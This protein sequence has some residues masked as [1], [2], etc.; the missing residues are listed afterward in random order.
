MFSILPKV[1]VNDLLTKWIPLPCVGK[2]DSALCSKHGRVQF[3]TFL[4]SGLFDHDSNQSCGGEAFYDWIL[5]RK[6]KLHAK[7]LTLDAVL[8]NNGMVRCKVLSMLGKKLTK[9]SIDSPTATTAQLER[10]ILDVVLY[11]TNLTACNIQRYT[12]LSITSML[13][14]NPNMEKVTLHE[15]ISPKESE[16]LH[17]IGLLCPQIQAIDIRANLEDHSFQSFLSAIPF[18][19][20]CLC[21][22]NCSK[23]NWNTLSDILQQCV[24]LHE[25]RIGTLMNS[26]PS[27]L[28]IVEHFGM[29]TFR[30]KINSISKT[31]LDALAQMMPRL[32]TAILLN[33]YRKSYTEGARRILLDFPYLRQLVTIPEC[34]NVLKSLQP[35]KFEQSVDGPLVPGSLLEELHDHVSLEYVSKIALPMLR[36][37]ACHNA[38]SLPAL[39]PHVMKVALISNKSTQND[40][41]IPRLAGLEEI[42][43]LFCHAMSD[44]I[45]R[46]IALQ[47]P[48]LKVLY[49]QQI[50]HDKNDALVPAISTEG[51]WIFLTLCPLLHTIKY[52]AS[53]RGIKDNTI[54]ICPLLRK[55]LFMSFPNLKSLVYSVIV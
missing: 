27:D 40:L 34:E 25:L 43:I 8:L 46:R 5:K 28:P 30:T 17:S 11:C 51:L 12:D 42:D 1:V 7:E 13:A 10:A 31:V 35:M 33:D 24:N 16:M 15:C 48:Q 14:R 54:S 21:L 20:Q 50:I 45:M 44:Q 3:F 26:L 49:L 41:V 36:V 55:S 37:I 18:S 32:T 19:M 39:P 4:E 38:D 22:C 6:V 23:F 53:N 29:R 2:L 47:N 52:T 9:L